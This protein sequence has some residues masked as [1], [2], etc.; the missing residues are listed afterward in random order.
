MDLR[1]YQEAVMRDE[2]TVI[3][4]V[5]LLGTMLHYVTMMGRLYGYSLEELASIDQEGK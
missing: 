1:D 4:R 2:K 3:E 5:K